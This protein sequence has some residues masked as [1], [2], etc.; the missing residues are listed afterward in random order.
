MLQKQAISFTFGS[1][2]QT[3]LDEFNLPVGQFV[4]VKNSVFDK[5]SRLTKRNGFGY[6]GALPNT[7]SSLLTTFNG[8]LT[9]IGSAFLA[10]SPSTVSWVNKGSFQSLKID[11]MPLIRSNTNQSAVDTA[12]SPNGLVCTVFTDNVTVGSTTVPKYK[13]AIANYE[14]GQNVVPPT[15]IIS[16]FGT[17]SFSSRVFALE[18]NFI[19]VFGAFNGVTYHLQYQALSSSVPG[20]VGSV[21]D[22]STSYFPSARGAFDGY[23][24]NNSLYLS[25]NAASNTGIRSA[26]LTSGLT[27]SSEVAIA[28]ATASIISVTADLSQSSPVIWTSAYIAGSNSGVIVATNQALTTLFAAKQFVSSSSAQ[29]LNIATTAQSGILNVFH[30]VS[31]FYTYGSVSNAVNKITSTQTGSLSAT[32]TI[33]RGVGLASKG[34][35]LNSSSY[36]LSAFSSTYQPSYFMI[37]STGMVVAKLAYSNGGGYLAQGLPSVSITGNTANVGYLIK[38]LVEAVNKETNPPTGT[39]LGGIYTQ[40]GINLAKFNFGSKNLSPCETASNL[41]LNGGFLWGYDGYS[42]T[43]SGFF[44]YPDDVLCTGSSSSGLLA[45]QQYY[46][47]AVYAWT[48][49][50]GN[51]YRSAPSLPAPVTVSSGTSTVTVNVPTYRLTYKTQNP[52]KIEIYRWSTAQQTYYQVTSIANPTIVNLAVDNDNIAFVD[53][54]SDAQIFAN[55]VLYTTGGVL[56]NISAPGSDAMTLFDNRLWLIDSENK[57]QLWYSKQIIQNTPVEMSDFLTMYVPPTTSTKITTGPMRCIAPLDDKLVIFKKNAIYYFNGQ[58]PDITGANS[59]YSQPILITSTVGC[60]NQSSII[61]TPNGLMFQSDKGIWLLGRDLNTTYIGSPVEAYNSA[62][63]LSSVAVPE[64]NQIRFTLNNG[65]TLMYDYFVNQWGVF[66]GIS[67]IS[68]TIYGG[69]HSFI[70]SYGQAFQETVGTYLDGSNAVL[71]SFTTGWMNLAGLQGYQRC[72]QMYLLGTYKTPHTLTM[73]IAYDFDS[74]IAQV[75]TISPDNY[76][77]PWGVGALWGSN[78]LWGGSTTREQWQINF[79]RQQCQSIQLTFNEYFDSTV[80][81]VT[82]GAGLTVSGV[83]IVAG[84]KKQYP[85]NI[86]PTKRV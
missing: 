41:F 47:Q 6:L 28:S 22:V 79:Q 69:L 65:L 58:G 55:N 31:N 38:D 26:Y 86:S 39:Q 16:T 51:I 25:W 3:K 74:S 35:I 82:A 45:P 20:V 60:S 10:Y 1:G 53:R 80:A 62:V 76:S 78:P 13:Y 84:V 36:F 67:G 49:N 18:N 43:E 19:V 4:L 73:G 14:T 23:V 59:Q 21:T 48:D 81:S 37:S 83:N 9:A 75:S 29:I 27:L 40:T 15:Q 12:I 52:V 24:A 5:I 8:N 44:V 61:Q 50:Q 70:D 66:E 11:T 85:R 64:T 54:L 71:M 56:E 17:V 63:V 32:T 72:Y 7:N 77:A 2:I 57:N 30:E 42:P 46:Y 33:T 68:S 34:F